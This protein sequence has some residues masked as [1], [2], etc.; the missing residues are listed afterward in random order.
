MSRPQLKLPKKSIACNPEAPLDT[1]TS[2][3]TPSRAGERKSSSDL[4]TPPVAGVVAPPLVSERTVD[5][6]CCSEQARL[7]RIAKRILGRFRPVSQSWFFTYA[8]SLM[9]LTD[10]PLNRSRDTLAKIYRY[11]DLHEIM[12]VLTEPGDAGPFDE[13][14]SADDWETDIVQAALIERKVRTID[15]IQSRN[16]NVRYDPNTVC[17]SDE[18][19]CLGLFNTPST[20]QIAVRELDLP[21]RTSLERRMRRNAF[22]I[23][24][25]SQTP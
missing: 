14:I 9:R 2:S 17:T 7:E 6:M 12:Q 11:K 18:V 4:S 21:K 24:I 19:Y 5:I 1:S 23:D 20:H 15:I 10:E 22:D 3:L 16:P 13:E 8:K 25:E